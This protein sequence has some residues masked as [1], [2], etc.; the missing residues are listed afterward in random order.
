MKEVTFI[1]Q[2]IEKWR[3]VQL[4]VEDAIDAAPDRQADAYIDLTSDLAFAQTHFPQSRITLYLNGLASALHN[5]IYRNK[6]EPLSRLWTF[7]T[8]EIP[9]TMYE[10]RGALL[11]SVLIFLASVIIGAVSQA[12]DADFARLILG[13]SYVD[14]TLENIANGEPMAVYNGGGETSMF[15]QITLNN[16]WVSFVVFVMGIFTSFG[17]GFYLFQNGVMLGSFQTFFFQQGFGL[18]L[19]S[20][21]AIWLHGTLEI[22]AI[23]VAGAAGITMGNGWLF[24]GTYSRMKSFMRGARRGTKIVVG[25]VPIFITAGFIESFATRHTEWPDVLR[26]AVILLSLTFVMTYYV[27]V[28]YYRYGRNN[29]KS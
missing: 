7:W 24:P 4:I 9:L 11:T 18:G 19:E 2:N 8:Q 1:R 25:T 6:R 15:L 5:M 13:D 20:M 17:T 27:I 21:L 22:S 14:M 16:I 23:I 3:D 28:P 10:A 29:D 12:H 26:L